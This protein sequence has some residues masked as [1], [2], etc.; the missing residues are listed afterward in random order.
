MTNKHKLI[1]QLGRTLQSIVWVLRAKFAF[2][3]KL[4]PSQNTERIL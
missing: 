3:E 1:Q 2:L 4:S